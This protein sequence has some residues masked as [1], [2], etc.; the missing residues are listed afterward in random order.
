[1]V[2]FSWG[3]RRK[4]QG[5]LGVA[6]AGNELCSSLPVAYYCHVSINPAHNWL[7]SAQSPDL[8]RTTRPDYPFRKYTQAGM[9]LLGVINDPGDQ[10][11]YWGDTAPFE[12]SSRRRRDL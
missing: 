7:E 2:R 12:C 11:F 9:A 6:P 8:S 5:E 10:W 3:I 4:A 1:M